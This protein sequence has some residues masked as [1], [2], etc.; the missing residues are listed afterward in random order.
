MILGWLHDSFPYEI[1]PSSHFCDI[2]VGDVFQEQDGIW[3]L[4]YRDAA[5]V[6]IV[7]VNW[8]TKLF[9]GGQINGRILTNGRKRT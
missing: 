7:K 8:F 1:F 5:K 6:Q 2:E 4:L 9:W 3:R